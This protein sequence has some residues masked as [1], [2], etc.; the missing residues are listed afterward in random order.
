[1]PKNTASEKVPERRRPSDSQPEFDDQS[2]HD[3]DSHIGAVEDEV[4]DV[5]APAGRAF[6]D[7]PRQG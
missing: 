5:P 7:E 6:E 4:V 3:E 2:P 1:M